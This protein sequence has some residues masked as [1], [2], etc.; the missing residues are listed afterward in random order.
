M[1]QARLNLIGSIAR[2]NPF[3]L[4]KATLLL[5]MHKF[6]IRTSFSLRFLGRRVCFPSISELYLVR[7]ILDER[8]YNIECANP[9][10]IVDLG[11]NI[12][13]ASIFLA[14][15]YPNAHIDA[16]EPDPVTFEYL[17]RNTQGLNVTCYQKA[18]AP[19]NGLLIFHRSSKSVASSL[20]PS[21][22]TIQS[23]QVQT[24]TPEDLGPMD[25]LK[26][27]VEGIERNLVGH[28][29]DAKHIVG[30]SDDTE[31]I[32]SLFHNVVWQPIRGVFCAS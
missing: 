29:F 3:A 11:A 8:I 10:R 21:K 22:D 7:Q 26:I 5:V 4:P 30:E 14:L 6:A 19:T 23:V 16:Y 13:I 9:K 15:K 17:K 12:G 32:T 18:I 28:I 27:D 1:F 2:L 24:V 31:A 25:I 20:I